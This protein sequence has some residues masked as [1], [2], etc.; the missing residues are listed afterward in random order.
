MLIDFKLPKIL[1]GGGGG[2]A[3][4]PPEHPPATGLTYDAF[5][6]NVSSLMRKN[7]SI[8]RN[9]KFEPVQVLQVRVLQFHV[10]QVPSHYR[11]NG[12]RM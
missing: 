2:G 4:V 1:G 7:V 6:Y 12:G 11:W 10:L 3:R 8:K 9:I 5:D